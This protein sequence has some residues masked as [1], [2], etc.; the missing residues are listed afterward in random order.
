MQ[1]LEGEL[2]DRLDIEINPNQLPDASLLSVDSTLGMVEQC[3]VSHLLR[4]NCPVT[5]QPDWASIQIKYAG[6]SI[7]EE[8]LLRYL[9]S[10]R[11]HHGH[12]RKMP[13]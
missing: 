11:E 13:P 8:G 10:L 12:Q 6:L 1:E 7:N 5:G 4:S 9:I 2:L 3:L